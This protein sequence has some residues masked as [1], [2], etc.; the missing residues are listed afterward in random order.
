MNDLGRERERETTLWEKKRELI[1]WS[2]VYS[3]F[4]L[5]I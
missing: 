5:L 2:L 1:W 3:D 4:D